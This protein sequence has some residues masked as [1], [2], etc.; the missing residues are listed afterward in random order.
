MP[1][2]FKHDSKLP[3]PSWP[4][5]N[6][7]YRVGL[8]FHRMGD[9]CGRTNWNVATRMSFTGMQRTSLGHSSQ[10]NAGSPPPMSGPSGTESC[11]STTEPNLLS[12]IFTSSDKDS[13]PRTAKHITFAE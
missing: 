3:L 11:L 10:A 4:M 9:C 12:T 1:F 8:V 6:D 13:L 5:R 7:K 2:A